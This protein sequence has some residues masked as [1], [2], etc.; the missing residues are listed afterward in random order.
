MRPV[1]RPP[2]S[3]KLLKVIWFGMGNRL[4]NGNSKIDEGVE[5]QVE[6]N[7][8]DMIKIQ[9]RSIYDDYVLYE[10]KGKGASA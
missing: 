5:Q 6:F 3:H 8:K 10:I 7:A 2:K 9:K 1:D 4:Q